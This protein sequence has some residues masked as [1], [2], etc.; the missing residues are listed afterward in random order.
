MEEAASQPAA[1]PSNLAQ[2]AARALSSSTHTRGPA[3][4]PGDHYPPARPASPAAAA[5]WPHASAAR[6][7]RPRV[8]PFRLQPLPRGPRKS[9]TPSTVS[10]PS[11]TP[12]PPARPTP[13]SGGRGGPGG[14][15]RDMALSPWRRTHATLAPRLRHRT[16]ALGCH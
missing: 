4:G 1:R 9:A 12:R 8:S 5:A 10:S 7:P 2:A 16:R 15:A 11:P 6:R 3:A 13:D 14:H